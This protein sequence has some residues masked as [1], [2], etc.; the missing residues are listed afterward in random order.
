MLNRI[1]STD[2]AKATKATSYGYFNAIQ[3]LAPAS[4]SGH[5]LCPHASAACIASCLGWF[6][7]QAG[8]VA[9]L[10]KD[11]NSVRRSRIQK[12]QLFMKERKAYM[13]DVVKAIVTTGSAATQVVSVASQAQ[14]EAYKAQFAALLKVPV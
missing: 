2:S 1:F 3:Y 12:A 13:V 4:T 6:S 10:E 9:D 5:N 8:M 7:G 14:L 11:M